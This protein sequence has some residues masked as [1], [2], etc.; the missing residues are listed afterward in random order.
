MDTAIGENIA[1]APEGSIPLFSWAVHQLQRNRE[2][3]ESDRAA[4]EP[5]GFEQKLLMRECGDRA[6]REGQRRERD[7]HPA[8]LSHVPDYNPLM[9]LSL[10]API[11][12]LV[13]V[14]GV[15]AAV[16]AQP[17]RRD[18]RWEVKM[19]MEMP[20]MPARMPPMTTTQCI[21]PEEAKDPQK[22]MPQGRGGRGNQNC[23]VSDYKETGNKVTWSMRCEGAE[24]MTG[25]GEFVYAGDTYTGTI[26]MEGSGRGAMAMK[27]TGKRLGDCTK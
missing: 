19:E 7:E 26:T 27:Y 20:G 9:K 11:A 6:D 4:P 21:T 2:Q 10:P 24:P 8:G 22:A 5:D 12:M 15:A 16:F 13:V 18:G 25:T 1:R 14:L 23:K 3:Q 17:P